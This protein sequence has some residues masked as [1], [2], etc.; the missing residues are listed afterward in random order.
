MGL[1]GIEEFDDLFLLD[2]ALVQPKRRNRKLVRLNPA[3]METW[4][5]LK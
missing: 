2:T 3:M 1:E 4:F 5:Q